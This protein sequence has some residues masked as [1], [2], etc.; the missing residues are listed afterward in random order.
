MHT[1]FAQIRFALIEISELDWL[2]DLQDARIKSL[3]TT[4]QPQPDHG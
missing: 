1:T 4:N 3:Q 2:L